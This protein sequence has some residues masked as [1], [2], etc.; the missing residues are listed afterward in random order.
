MNAEHKM[1]QQHVVRAQQAKPRER[2][3]SAAD[4]LTAK[5]GCTSKRSTAHVSLKGAT[6][7][8]EDTCV[9]HG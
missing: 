9:Q 5:P 4:A 1:A 2:N 6:S 7:N 8:T 3:A